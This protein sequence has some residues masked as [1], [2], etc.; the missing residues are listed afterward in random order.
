MTTKNQRQLQ[1]EK[2]KE[3]ILD[4]I[5]AMT[6]DRPISQ[7]TIREI[8][9]HAGVSPGAFYHHFDSKEAAI[10]YSYRIADEEFEKLKRT[11]TPIENIRSIIHTQ[12]G[13]LTD[14]TINATKSLYISHLVYHDVYFFDENRP[15]FQVLKQEIAAYT[16]L[17]TD[18][19]KLRALVWKILS[20]CRGLLYNSCIEHK[21][22]AVDWPAVQVDEAVQYFLFCVTP[23]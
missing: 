1:A 17:R 11:G 2:T 19:E 23:K 9:N 6:Q 8:C 22:L 20:F 10:L 3:T 15:I 13:M 16:G 7:I 5:R 12:L 18:N 21:K 4:T 14:E